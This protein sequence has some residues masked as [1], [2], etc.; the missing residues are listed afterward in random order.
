MFWSDQSLKKTFVSGCDPLQTG[1]R[2]ETKKTNKE[3]KAKQRTP[4]R[5]IFLYRE[6][7]DKET[8]HITKRLRRLLIRIEIAATFRMRSGK[9]LHENSEIEQQTVTSSV[10]TENKT[11]QTYHIHISNTYLE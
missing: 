8:A 2:T 11:H 10:T 6:E 5:D 4:I 9:K 1:L 7:S 3:G